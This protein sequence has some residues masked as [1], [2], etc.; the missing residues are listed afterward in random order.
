MGTP[1]RPEAWFNPATGQFAVVGGDGNAD[2]S[3]ATALL[4]EAG[5]VVVL[6]GYDQ[7]IRP[8]DQ[9]LRFVP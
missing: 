8:T 3:F 6:G 5:S 9:V 4:T 1:P 2:S 7:L